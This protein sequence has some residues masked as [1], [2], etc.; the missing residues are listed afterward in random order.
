M[1][2]VPSDTT[3]TLGDHVV[4]RAVLDAQPDV[5]G[6][7][8]GW[9]WS[10]ALVG[11]VGAHAGGVFTSTSLFT[12]FLAPDVDAAADSAASMRPCSFSLSQMTAR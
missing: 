3:V 4:I 6:A 8:L 2:F 12:E 10:P 7:S 9:T 1:T 5:K 11:F